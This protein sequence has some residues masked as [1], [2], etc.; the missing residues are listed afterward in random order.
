MWKQCVVLISCLSFC[1][2]A[3]L[4]QFSAAGADTDATRVEQLYAMQASDFSAGDLQAAY[5]AA[6]AAT[7]E[8]G[9]AEPKSAGWA[10]LGIGGALLF[11]VLLSLAAAGAAC[12]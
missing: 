6:P 5:S 8:Q 10:L 12:C 1:G 3:S 4:Q 2:C 9:A 11:L 7:P